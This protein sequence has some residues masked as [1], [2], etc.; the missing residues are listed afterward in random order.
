MNSICKYIAFVFALT[1]ISG[2]SAQFGFEYAPTIPVSRSSSY[3]ENAWGGGFNYTQVADFDYDFDGDKDL[4][5]FDR[6]SNNI[7]VLVQEDNAGTP[8]YRT[9]FYAKN[10]FPSDLRY[11]ATLVDYDNDGRKDIFT[12][13][14]GGLKVYR[15]IG[16]A[17]NGLQWELMDDLIYSQYPSTY[18][19]LYVSSTD[20]PAI[21]DVDNDGDIDVLTFHQGGQHI[22]YH[23][24]QSVELYGIPDSLIFELKNECWGK[25]SE[26]LTTNSVILND[27]NS[28]CVGGSIANPLRLAGDGNKEAKHSGSTVMAFDYDNSGVLDLVL[29]DV[30]FTNL[31]LLING[32]T[33]PNTNSAMI[34]QDLAFPSNTTPASMQLFPA[35]FFVD[36]DFDNKRDLVVTANARN[37]SENETSIRY[38]KNIGSDSNPNF[39]YIDNDY[40][41]NQMIDHGT[42]SVPVFF[43][44]DE[45]GLEDMFVANFYRYIPV[46]A[47]ES[48]IA[49]YKNTGTA[50]APEFTYIDYNFLN[51]DQEN[52][53]L[54][55][56]PTFGDIDNDGDKDLIL[57]REDGTLI[58]YENT[59]TGSGS[60]FT[61]GQINY[62]D[63]LGNPINVTAYSFPQLFDLNKDGLLDLIIGNKAGNIAYYKNIGTV[64]SPSFELSN[65]NLGMVNVSTTLPDGYATPHF[66]EVNNE[67]KLFVGN[68]DGSLIYYDSID[69][70]LS[71][72]DDFHLV[73]TDYVG[74]NVE[75]YSSVYVNDINNDGNFNLFMGQDLGGIFHFETNPN[76]SAFI[77]ELN[78]SYGISV[79]PNPFESTFTI[80]SNDILIND[81][82]VEDL[83][84]RRINQFQMNGFKTMIDLSANPKG[85]YFIRATLT[86]QKVVV[87]KVIKY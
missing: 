46:S 45:D 49:Y 72:T 50:L 42:G 65:A 68:I 43:D 26:D 10:F 60:V 77:N 64:N 6:S 62:A 85:I 36:V 83:N 79:Y 17:T 33:A 41:Q 31:V 29:G 11:R 34:S 70:N 37:I 78:E 30:S 12:Y 22:E 66:F 2:V 76:S 27:P 59:S 75:A 13:G 51:L 57:G 55:T 54:R 5:M 47:K 81:V 58:Y 4:F 16:D 67:T 40:F 25:F 56:I 20:I 24:N 73:A 3:L 19:N 74:I 28:P 48:T 18:T 84:G 35:A 8:Y 63:N 71:P 69:N 80:E 38:Y 14:I 15:N 52:Y 82:V 86:N 23:Q 21:I 39:I 7:R 32:G 61:T 44:F 87:K 53:G 1:T 9:D